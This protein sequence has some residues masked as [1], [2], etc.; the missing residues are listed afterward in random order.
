MKRRKMSQKEL[1]AW[2]LLLVMFHRAC[3]R[4]LENM[5]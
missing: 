2:C 4:E 5:P 1:R 3:Q